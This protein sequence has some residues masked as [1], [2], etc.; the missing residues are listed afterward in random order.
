MANFI[1]SLRII[2]SILLL[3]SPA[4]S[5]SFY[6]LYI[7]AGITDMIDGEIA[8]K[9]NT[10]NEFGS[11]LDTVADFIMVAACFIKLVPV[12]SIDK[13]IYVWVAVIAVIKVA[14]VV[15]F[16][17]RHKKLVSVHSVMNKVTGALLFVLPF[18]VKAV[19]LKYSAML[20]CAVATFAAIQE[21]YYIRIQGV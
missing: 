4:L 11:K 8:R 3:F 15:L 2:C 21:A 1:T 6:A 17:A 9:T 16:Y 19:D 10:V 7:A 5:A 13:W 12:L 18:T 14:N 20:V